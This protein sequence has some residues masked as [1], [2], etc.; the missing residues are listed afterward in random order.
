MALLYEIFG[1]VRTRLENVDLSVDRVCNYDGSHELCQ[2]S[3][4]QSILVSLSARGIW[5][6][7]QPSE[8][9]ESI[10]TLQSKLSNLNG[11]GSHPECRL[12]KIIIWGVWYR[13]KDLAPY[14]T[15]RQKR[16]MEARASESGI[17]DG[18]S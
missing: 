11:Q 13:T 3:M 2:Q 8:Y 1:H 7:P 6:I 10:L 9:K 15:E 12:E 14:I 4:I 18:R 5:P 16:H 17:N